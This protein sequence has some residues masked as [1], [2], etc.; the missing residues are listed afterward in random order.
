[1]TGNNHKPKRLLTHSLGYLII[2]FLPMAS[3]LL[4]APILTKYLTPSEYSILTIT[5]IFQSVYLIMIDVGI[6]GAFGRYFFQFRHKDR[7]LYAFLSTSLLLATLLFIFAFTFFIFFGDSIVSELIQSDSF[8]SNPYVLLIG[9][10]TFFTVIQSIFL[11][12][13]RNSK[14][15]KQYG[16]LALSSF[17]ISTIL[18]LFFVV[19]YNRGAL[20]VLEGKLIGLFLVVCTTLLITYK[21][22]RVEVK[23]KYAR[24]ILVFGFPLMIYSLLDSIIFHFDKW[25]VDRFLTPEQLGVYG[26]A[27]AISGIPNIVINAGSSVVL[28]AI[29]EEL[30]NKVI[31][32]DSI[33]QQVNVFLSFLLSFILVVGIVIK[34]MVLFFID[35][36]Y[37]DMIPIIPIMLA[38]YIFRGFFVTLAVPFY[39]AKQTRAFPKV[40]FFSLIG[41]V[42]AGFIL[43]PKYG[44]LGAAYTFL[45]AKVLQLCTIAFLYL[46]ISKLYKEIFFFNK[47]NLLVSIF[48]ALLSYNIWDDIKIGLFINC[49][50]LLFI[51][52]IFIKQI[53]YGYG[54]R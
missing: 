44:I 22:I 28:P 14:N 54:T 52:F 9:L 11:S 30:G 43:V 1:M 37:H 35:I 12:L 47:Y 7:L 33:R 17:F 6:S 50:F 31:A 39:Y 41:A 26:L 34:P 4:L 45:I 42:I 18:S 2:G 8:S 5:A 38:G 51:I 16:V 21:N 27:F 49:F 13:Y 25:L 40:N 3:N 23:W 53:R 46:G 29:Y 10:I 19:N 20:G 48:L 15:I 24:Y 32:K 36:K